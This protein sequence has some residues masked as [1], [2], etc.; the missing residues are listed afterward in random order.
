MSVIHT[1]ESAAGK[2]LRKWEFGNPAD[3][4]RGYRESIVGPWPTMLYQAGRLPGGNVGIVSSQRA[5]NEGEARAAEAKG[6]H[7]GGQLAAI[8]AF[9]RNEREM[10][11][12]AANRAYQ[13]RGMSEAA[14]REIAAAEAET[15]EHLPVI[16]EKRKPG[17]PKKSESP[18]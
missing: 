5:E 17:R 3:G 14:Q 1:P 6:Y 12:L 9:H 18:A 7:R 15:D 2:E 11:K 13:D 8:E 4:Y 10:A 16:P